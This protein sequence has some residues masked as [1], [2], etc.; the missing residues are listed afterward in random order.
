M[1]SIFVS[2]Y[3]RNASKDSW[4]TKKERKAIGYMLQ[5]TNISLS[6]HTWDILEEIQ[7]KMLVYFIA[8]TQN[9][10]GKKEDISL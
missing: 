6:Y 8:E 2:V 10:L 4:G 3:L 1:L 9:G 5:V 7:L